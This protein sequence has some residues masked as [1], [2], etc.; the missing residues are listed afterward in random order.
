[1][2]PE[3]PTDRLPVAVVGGGAI[4]PRH[5]QAY[6]ATGRTD[7]VGVVDTVADRARAFAAEYGTTAFT[8]VDELLSATAPRLVSVATP[9]GSHLDV[10]RELLDAGTSIIVEKPPVLSLAQLDRLAELDER[11]AGSVSVVFQ[12]RFGSGAVRA[13]ELLRSG[14][15]GTPYFVLCETSWYRP[16]N[17][18]D[19]EW[20]G[21]WSGEGG[22]PT[23]GHGIHQID[24]MLH[25]LGPWRTVDA[26]TFRLDRPVEFEDVSLATV[27]FENG[28]VG[29]VINSLLSPRELTRV[30]IDTSE[31]S[32]EVNHLYGYSDRD[33]SFYP[34]PG[35][36]QSLTPGADAGRD[37]AASGDLW[38]QTAGEDLPSN[39]EA[40]LARLV[41]DV[42]AGRTHEATVASSRPTMEFVTA[43]YASAF[44]G[45]PVD[46][47]ELVPGHPFYDRLD[48]GLAQAEI[49]E[50]VVSGR[51]PS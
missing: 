5:A 45:R 18:F 17:Y 38:S 7:L 33:W 8:S 44:T 36:A 49:D 15:L 9:P 4:G 48:G 35:G 42:L 22:G 50:I 31:G 21:T 16:R 43:L 29:S 25:L 47:A 26:S 24:L 30:R 3:S 28:A 13:R 1:M 19:P 11:S 34:V 23:L 6:A 10:A 41:D 51:R 20:R 12:H 14:E 46:R 32:L 37:S 27:V 39:H 40:Q 2:T